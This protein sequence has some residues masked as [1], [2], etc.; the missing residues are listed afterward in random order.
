[1]DLPLLQMNARKNK[2]TLAQAFGQSANGRCCRRS[3]ARSVARFA[4]PRAEHKTSITIIKLFRWFYHTVFILSVGWLWV[5]AL[6]P[7]THFAV[8]IVA[9]L[10][11]AERMAPSMFQKR[12]MVPR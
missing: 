2:S 6:Q 5:F 11:S 8:P 7:G 4:C 1:M 12:E 9:G 3:S 10:A